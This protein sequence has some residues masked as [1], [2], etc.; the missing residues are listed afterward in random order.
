MWHSAS[1]DPKAKTGLTAQL[2]NRLMQ[3]FC[4]HNFSWPHT[5]RHGQ[6]YQVC[7]ICGATYEYDFNTM[8]RGR[9]VEP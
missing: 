7:L 2:L 5:G 3:S 8:R 6:D 4:R 1:S 9:L